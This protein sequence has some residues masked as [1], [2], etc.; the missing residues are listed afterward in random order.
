MRRCLRLLHSS[1]GGNVAVANG[2]SHLKVDNSTEAFPGDVTKFGQKKWRSLRDENSRVD[3]KAWVDGVTLDQEALD[4]IRACAQLPIIHSHIAVMPDVHYGK[5]ATVGTII[6]TVNAIIPAAVGVDIGCGMLAVETTLTANDLPDSLKELRTN[7]EICVPHGRTHNGHS[8]LDAGSW[9][10]QPTSKVRQLWKTE[11]V[12]GFERLCAKYPRLEFTNH[13]NHLGT[14]GTGNHFVEVHL[15]EKDAVWFMLHSGSRG[16][17]NAIG[18][19]FIELAKK[20]MGKHLANLPDQD[21]AYIKEG[22]T[23]F[24]DYVDAVTWAQRYARVNRHLMMEAMIEATRRTKGIPPFKAVGKAVN[25]HHNYVAQE[26]HFGRDVWVTRKGAVRA[27]EG[28]LGIIPG[29]MGADCYIVRGKGNPESFMSCSHGAGRE[30]SRVQAKRSFSVQEH[31]AATE[32]IECRK[33]RDVLDET[34]GAYKPIAAV[35]DAQ[36]DL[37]EIV[38]RLKQIV[39]VKG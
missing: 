36:T 28:D 3:V 27:Y 34:P 37:I 23:Y 6:P 10:S 4:Q 30:M 18:F 31:M 22:S 26:R 24:N 5:A 21:L 8:S 15:D 29:S 32:G 2:G 17:G 16:V 7:L 20:D 13:E 25:C 19:S 12:P 9:R 1:C 33:D 39:C 38:A 11:L 14:L 35:I